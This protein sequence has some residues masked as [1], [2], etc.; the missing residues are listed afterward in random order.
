MLN[1]INTTSQAEVKLQFTYTNI[2]FRK[3]ILFI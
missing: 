2:L 1:V 3:G